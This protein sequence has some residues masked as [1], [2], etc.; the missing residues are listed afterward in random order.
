MENPKNIKIQDKIYY[1]YKLWYMHCHRE[2]QRAAQR[3]EL[4]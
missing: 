4:W 2:W 3:N 1:G